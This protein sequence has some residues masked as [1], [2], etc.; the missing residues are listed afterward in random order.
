MLEGKKGQDPAG[1]VAEVQAA[2]SY[3]PPTAE[4]TLRAAQCLWVEPVEACGELWGAGE[5]T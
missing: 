1:G 5:Y 3:Y 2:H 4:A